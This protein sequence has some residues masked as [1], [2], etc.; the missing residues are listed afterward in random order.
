MI[1]AQYTIYFHQNFSVDVLNQLLISYR[2]FPYSS[3][4]NACE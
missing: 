1:H 2:H 3:E 4:V